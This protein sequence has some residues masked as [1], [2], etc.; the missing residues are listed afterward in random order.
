MKSYYKFLQTIAIVF[1]FGSAHAAHLTNEI[2]LAARINGSQQVPAVNTTAVGVGGFSLN[3]SMDTMCITITCTGLSGPITAAHIHSGAMGMNGGVVLDLTSAIRGN[4][5]MA[6]VYGADL[7]PALLKNYLLGMHYINIHTAANPNGEIRGQVLL[8]TDN[9]YTAPIN[10]MQQVP[11]VT[12]SAMGMG[13]F[14]LSKSNKRLSFH[15]VNNNLSGAITSVHLHTGAAGTNG[16][17]AV[18]LTPFISMNNGDIISGEVNP[19][20]FLNDLQTGNIYINV[21]TAANPNGEIR[22]QLMLDQYI[23]FDAKLDGAQQSPA[24]TTTAGGVAHF[25]LSPTRDTLWYN[26]LVEGLSDTITSAHLH[27]AALGANGPVLVDIGDDIDGNTIKGMVTG[28]QLTSAIIDELLEANVYLNIHTDAN[29]S[30]EIRGQVLRFV[31]EAYSTNINGIQQVPATTSTAVGSGIVT[32]DRDQKEAHY[33]IVAHGLMVDDVHFHKN[34]FGQNGGVLYDLSPYFVNNGA[35][36]YWTN[37]D[38]A[39]IFNTAQSLNFRNDSVYVNFHTTAFPA[40]EIRGQVDRGYACYSAAPNAISNVS[41]T[42]LKL[43]PN[44]ADEILNIETNEDVQ[45]QILSTTGAVLQSNK[46]SKG[47]NTINISKLPQG[48]YMIQCINQ[49]NSKTVHRFMKQ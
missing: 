47:Y 2:M 28:T 39:T 15:V 49:Y 35:F 11:M 40:G 18:D 16:G 31:R 32:I 38:T 7:T 12:T 6:T 41:S 1:F 37:T 20:S 5:I 36:G 46:A 30:G 34:K 44:P 17:V 33:M 43:Y 26:V 24:V 10:G 45:V 25:R 42:Q 8:E 14:K 23:S 21:H 3:A 19:T 22:G 9:C 13:V 48:C 4:Q 29:P 27:N